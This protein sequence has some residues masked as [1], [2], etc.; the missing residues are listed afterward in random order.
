[1]CEDYKSRNRLNHYAKERKE[2]DETFMLFKLSMTV[3]WAY[4]QIRISKFKNQEGIDK[5]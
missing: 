4:N 3:K 1:M 2:L 5:D